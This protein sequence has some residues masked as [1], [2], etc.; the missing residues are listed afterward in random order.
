M[1][2]I[3]AKANKQVKKSRLMEQ[4]LFHYEQNGSSPERNEDA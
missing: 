3:A 4:M 2:I 1:A